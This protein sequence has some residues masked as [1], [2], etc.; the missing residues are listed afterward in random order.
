[1]YLLIVDT[2]GIQPYIFG[3]NRLQENIG[4]SYLVDQATRNWALE[5]V[6][7]PNNIVDIKTSQLNESIH[8]N[9]DN[10][11]AAEVIYSGGGNFVVLLKDEDKA[12]EF[13]RKLSRKVLSDAPNLQIVIAMEKFTWAESLCKTSQKVFQKL[14]EQKQ[15]RSISNP[16]L[17]LGVTASC[18]S[19][20]LPAVSYY[21][22][23]PVSAEILAKLDA[24]DKANK[25]L[26][27]TFS[28][29]LK[30]SPF[31]FPK[32]FDDMGRSY[33]E[34]SYIAVVHADGNGMGKIIEKIGDNFSQP[35]QNREYINHIRAFSK[36]VEQASKKA[37]ENT[38]Y[39]LINSV[40][41]VNNHYNIIHRNKQE[42]RLTE[43]HLKDKN[44]PFRPIVFGG[45][46][47]TFVC[48]GRLGISLAIK[49]LQEFECQTKNQNILNNGG[50]PGLTACAGIS[51]VKTHYPFARAY[52]LAEELCK[53]AKS[54]RKDEKTDDSCLDWHFALSGLSGKIETI[55]KREY[56]VKEG[57]LH[58][59]PV[60]LHK[61]ISQ[62]IHSWQTVK[63]ALEA[64]QS[65][66]WATRRNKIKALR[67]ALREGKDD[68]E[69]FINKF[70][71]EDGLPELELSDADYRKKGWHN[72]ECPYF[73]AIEMMDWFI[74]LKEEV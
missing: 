29:L 50:K 73:D 71:D 7:T 6:P 26:T 58:W 3:S 20:G 74:P 70:L 4:A 62:K 19:T 66:D 59:R 5:A 53:S 54:F 46:D 51:I 38:L 56:E 39:S 35:T 8:I 68:I 17:G 47:V 22:D 16:L 14:A 31:T 24:V 11:L 45:D 64:F 42:Q 9:K 1:M 28:S 60:T 61:N 41:P 13:T 44:L 49:Y 15:C 43:I 30:N 33:G 10:S 12:K 69:Q 36:N 37:L 18:Q 21:K 55:R 25:R 34:H 48:D 63:K 40:E 23:Y 67:E 65:S 27:D 72:K 52:E 57:K 2:T 32:E